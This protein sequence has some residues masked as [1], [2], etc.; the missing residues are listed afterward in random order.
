VGIVALIAAMA[1]G[2]YAASGGLT[3]KQKKEVKAIAK[4][5]QGAGPAGSQG[6]AGANGTSGKDGANGTAGKDGTN[7]APGSP[8]TAGGTLPSKATETGVWSVGHIEN[9]TQF[10]GASGNPINV[11]V[12][13]PVPLASE[14]DYFHV[15]FIQKNNKEFVVRV[16][17]AEEV[18]EEEIVQPDCPGTVDAPSAK[19]GNL[20][21]YTGRAHGLKPFKNLLS[22]FDG[23]PSE[24]GFTNPAS[25]ESGA[26]V[27]GST[28]E[29]F[30]EAT[31]AATADVEGFGTWAVT[32]P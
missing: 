9:T 22:E 20:C 21:V 13:F 8:W 3:S 32:A 11:P 28:L 27:A 14:L 12:S 26:A 24:S 16:T 10:P 30:W 18:L 6:P 2:A 29:M 5:F 17:P 7:G 23:L 4:S 31:D 19:P 1:G 15:H 25:G